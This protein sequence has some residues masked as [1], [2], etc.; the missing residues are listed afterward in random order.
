MA[1]TEAE[2]I[3]AKMQKLL[4]EASKKSPEELV[5]NYKGVLYPSSI[6][7][8]ETFQALESLEARQDDLM[9]VTYPKCVN[10]ILC[11]ICGLRRERRSDR[12]GHWVA[13]KVANSKPSVPV[14]NSLG[15][16]KKVEEQYISPSFLQGITDV[17]CAR[18]LKGKPSPR[19]F[20]TH[21]YPDDLPKSFFEKKVKTLLIL[22]NPKDT[23]VSYY[24][25]ANK[26]PL[27]PSFDSWELFFEAYMEGKVCFGSYFEYAL[28]WNKHIDEENIMVVTF[29]NL[30]EDFKSELLKISDFLGLS[31]TDEQI[32]LVES[33][34]TFKSMKENSSNTHGKLG[35]VFFRKGEIADWK[36]YFTE[37]QSKELDAKFEETLAGT[38][39]GEKINY[40]KYCTF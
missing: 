28:D 3:Q 35:D 18:H 29:E 17:G 32:A 13:V 8:T 16:Q 7:S 39:L 6:C 24:H 25:F 10:W 20:A 2:T 9:I 23:A 12:R 26:N 33:K 19:L 14:R 15:N 37:E 4:A 11:V 36:N 5:F 1:E 30:K 21:M 34:T 27:L 38:K 22:R 40:N 31:L